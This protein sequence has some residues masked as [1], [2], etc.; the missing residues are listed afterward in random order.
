M[1]SILSY[2]ALPHVPVSL[3][4]PSSLRSL[5]SG[6]AAD[7]LELRHATQPGANNSLPPSQPEA[8]ELPS[9]QPGATELHRLS[10]D[11]LTFSPSQTGI[12]KVPPSQPEA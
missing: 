10:M 4:L 2:P 1:A 11:L 12:V 9:T 3:E 8:D 5:D 7:R 6:A